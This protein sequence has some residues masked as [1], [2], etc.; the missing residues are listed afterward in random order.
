[1]SDYTVEV[2]T[3][4]EFEE[5]ATAVRTAVFVEEQGVSEDEELDGNDSDAVQFLASDGEQPVGTARLRFPESTV[6]KVERVAVREPHRGDGVGAALMRAAEDAARDDGATKLKLHA[7]THVEPFYQQ[8][9]Y[10][11]VSD[12]FEE[13]GIP[14]VEMRKQ[15]NG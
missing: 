14:H 6:G 4:E 10:E 12:E 2:G 13:A 5:A 1:M 9:G 11:T 8:L 15:L 3:W 7:Q